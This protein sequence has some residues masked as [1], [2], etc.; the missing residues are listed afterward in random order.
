MPIRVVEQ[1]ILEIPR[2]EVYRAIVDRIET[3]VY[4]VDVEGKILYWNYGAEKLAGFLSQD[5]LGRSCRHH[6]LV[7]YD[8]H[9]PVVCAHHCPLESMRD[10]ARQ[11]VVPYLRHRAAHVVPVRLWTMA[12]KNRAGDIVGAVKVFSKKVVL[13]ELGHEEAS[14]LRPEELDPESGVP[15]RASTE[16]FLRVQIDNSEKQRVPCGLIVIHVECLEGF[17][18]AHGME[19]ASAIVR[20]VARTLKDMVR[21]PTFSEGG[22]RIA[23]W[24]CCRVAG[25]S[26]SREWRSR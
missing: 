2:P 3:G 1:A 22:R 11:E 19:A 6:I 24:R 25:S 14:R 20:E 10:G 16:V 13:P 26:R 18:Q 7:E 9:N 21:R 17:R 5:V 23:F 15:S 8:D 12:L 4:A